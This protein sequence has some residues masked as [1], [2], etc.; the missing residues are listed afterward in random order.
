M[1]SPVE[2][3][4]PRGEDRSH[5]LG[6][7]VSIALAVV[8]VAGVVVLFLFARRELWHYFTHPE[9]LRTLVQGWGAWAPLG[10][11]GFQVLQI[12]VAPLPGNVVSFGCG[13]A[14]GFWPG[15]LWVMLGVLVGASID[16]LLARFLGRRLMRYLVPPDRLARLDRAVVRRGTF[17]MFLLLLIP[18]LTGDAG[19]VEEPGFDCCQETV[20]QAVTGSKPSSRQKPVNN[21]IRTAITGF[22][23]GFPADAVARRLRLITAAVRYT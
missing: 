16:F 6:T 3:P 12:V 10:I 15:I 5:R 4:E 21:R 17:Y 11:I 18:G 13:Y 9:E 8:L 20:A 19:A 22:G 2:N 1:T 7:A 14:M 23:S